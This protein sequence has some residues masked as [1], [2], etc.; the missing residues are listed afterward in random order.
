MFKIPSQL[1]SFY[2][3]HQYI[4]CTAAFISY[5]SHLFYEKHFIIFKL[6]IKLILKSCCIE[7][8]KQGQL[9]CMT[10]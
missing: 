3:K 5:H 7:R 1:K 8:P 9:T 4:D 2:I 10:R 6:D